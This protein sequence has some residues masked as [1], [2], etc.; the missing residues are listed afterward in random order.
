M[1]KWQ[2][3]QIRKFRKDA[4]FNQMFNT[5]RIKMT[6]QIIARLKLNKESVYYINKVRL[7]FWAP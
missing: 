1:Y 6:E 4:C 7:W 5:I 3:T 2:E